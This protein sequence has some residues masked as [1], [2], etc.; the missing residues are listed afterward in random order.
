MAFTPCWGGVL[1][2]GCGL[3]PPGSECG[4]VPQASPLGPRSSSSR[5]TTWRSTASPAPRRSRRA[6]WGGCP[7]SPSGAPPLSHMISLFIKDTT[8]SESPVLGPHQAKPSGSSGQ[9]SSSLLGML[10]RGALDR[11]RRP[12]I[13][14]GSGW[15]TRAGMVAAVTE[16]GTICGVGSSGRSVQAGCAAV[17]PDGLRHPQGLFS[18]VPE[19]GSGLPGRPEWGRGGWALMAWPFHLPPSGTE[20]MLSHGTADVVLEACTDFWDGAD[21]YP[22][23]GSDRWARKHTPRGGPEPPAGRSAFPAHR[24]E[25]PQDRWPHIRPSS[26]AERKCWTS[27]SEPACP[28]TAPPSPTSP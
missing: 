15:G 6:P 7:A 20:Q 4:P 13:Q 11:F 8:T 17:R 26:P 1:G 19:V 22:L 28:V 3:P 10:D 14:Q 24:H 16:D 23:S 12:E 21:I 9:G 5:R 2:A 27:T 25:E 18:T